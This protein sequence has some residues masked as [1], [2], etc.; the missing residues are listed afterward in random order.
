MKKLPKLCK[1]NVRRILTVEFRQNHL[2][3][4]GLIQIFKS[5]SILP[6]AQ[7]PFS[8]PFVQRL[9]INIQEFGPQHKKFLQQISYLIAFIKLIVYNKGILLD[10]RLQHISRLRVIQHIK[11]HR[12]RKGL[13]K[14]QPAERLT[15]L[16]T[17]R[18]VQILFNDVIYRVAFSH[19]QAA[20]HALQQHI[21]HG[22][23][24]FC[25]AVYFFHIIFRQHTAGHIEIP[26]NLLSG[27]FQGFFRQRKA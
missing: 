20:L 9:K 10:Q 6:L 16:S 21:H 8:G 5:S 14:G 22:Y 24:A 25:V 2:Y 13:Q 17:E 18:I 11:R 12:D 26:L 7:I 19:R 23:P 4:A 3:L 1:L 27:K 15:R